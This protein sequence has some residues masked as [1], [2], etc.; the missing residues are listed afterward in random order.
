MQNDDEKVKAL[1]FDLVRNY[2]VEKFVVSKSSNDKELGELENSDDCAWV[3]E[4]LPGGGGTEI[5][6][7]SRPGKKCASGHCT[8][9]TI[10]YT[11]PNG[12]KRTV[13]Y[14]DCSGAP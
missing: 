4:D 11:H 14:C 10:T 7:K 13:S 2:G 9:I 8:G 5:K 12:E 3:E 6:C 1:V